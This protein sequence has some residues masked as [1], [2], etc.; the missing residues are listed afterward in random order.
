MA[1]DSPTTLRD[2]GEDGLLRRLA[3]ML[4][5]HTG[6]MP[7]GTGDDAAVSAPTAHPG[8]IV[9]TIDTMTEGTHFR[10]WRGLPPP[11]WLGNMLARCNLSDLAAMG[12][13]PLYALLS[14]G[15]P[16]DARVRDIDAFFAGLDR[17]L[18]AAGA[19]LIGGD[20]V[21]APQWTLTLALTGTLAAGAI[22]A[23][24]SAARAG[25]GIYVTGFPGRHAAGLRLL[26]AGEAAPPLLAR[27]Y[28]NDPCTTL[29]FAE[30]VVA[31]GRRVAAID[32]S[33]GIACD[34]ARVAEASGVRL[35]V[36][37]EALPIADDLRAECHARGWDAEHLAL[38]GGEDY[39]L[40]VATDAG[41]AT[42]ARIAA[43]TGIRIARIGSVE[44]GTGV[45]LRRAGREEP[46]VFRGF[47]H[48][49]PEPAP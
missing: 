35:R 1:S 4:A 47:Q 17:A 22:P 23:T 48:F 46:L 31:A 30:A 11:D 36:E 2:L 26:E 27:A 44:S 45:A 37:A 40:L 5:R 42:M 25:D 34:A 3:P 24:R 41:D 33:D 16:A 29:A 43:D 49:T 20:T 19:R 13:R 8:R 18:S 12:A 32:L 21:N 39:E 10:L 9:W 38:H 6:G 14:F 7:L 28:V 15:A